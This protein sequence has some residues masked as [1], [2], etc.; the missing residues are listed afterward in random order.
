[1]SKFTRVEVIDPEGLVFTR[2]Y[3]EPMS[4]SAAIQDDGRTVKIFVD[5]AEDL[6]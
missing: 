5:K 3:D 1:M 6:G 2:Y 4:V